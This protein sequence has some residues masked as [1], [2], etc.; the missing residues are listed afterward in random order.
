MC[1]YVCKQEVEDILLRYY[2]REH[3]LLRYSR[4][5]F[6]E[7]PDILYSVTICC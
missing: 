5:T 4:Q 2:V 1:I 7:C 3:I 6:C